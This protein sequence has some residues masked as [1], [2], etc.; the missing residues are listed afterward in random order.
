M[1]Q[2]EFVFDGTTK[3]AYSQMTG[4]ERA[5]V[6][7]RNFA[8]TLNTLNSIEDNSASNMMQLTETLEKFAAQGHL[9]GESISFMAAMSA[10]FG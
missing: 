9:T 2:T 8:N 1:Q 10:V 6:V 4:M 3:A 7:T 5:D